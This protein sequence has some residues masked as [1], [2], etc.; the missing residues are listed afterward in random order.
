MSAGKIF[1]ILIGTF[2]LLTSFG[3][4]I[5]GSALLIIN[6]AAVDEDGYLTSSEITLSTMDDRSVAI[7]VDSIQIDAESDSPS[8][9]F[10][11][12]PVLFVQF[13]LQLPDNDGS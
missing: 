9:S 5:G 3:L 1:A 4:I 11:S 7:V 12:H 8:S 10:R 2:L 6:E 13:R